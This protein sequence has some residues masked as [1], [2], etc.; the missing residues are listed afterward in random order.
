MLAFRESEICVD[1]RL[2]KGREAQQKPTEAIT[3]MRTTSLLSGEATN[4][5]DNQAKSVRRRFEMSLPSV[6]PKYK[7]F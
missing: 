7:L 3:T 5:I 2:M 4:D 1:G 6:R